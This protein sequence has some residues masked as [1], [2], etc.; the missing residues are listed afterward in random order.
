VVGCRG[1]VER[2]AA[3]GGGPPAGARVVGLTRAGAWAELAAIA[4]SVLA[5]VPGAVSDV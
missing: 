3:D 4:T 5:P 2:T 1:V